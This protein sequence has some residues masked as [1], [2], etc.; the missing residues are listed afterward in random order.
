MEADARAIM[1]WRYPPPYAV[2]NTE[3]DGDADE[4]V[5][6]AEYLD[7]RSPYFA[8]RNEALDPSGAVVG[9]F[10]YGSS[11][12]VSLEA[13]APHLLEADGSLNVGLG[14]RPDLT[15]RGLGLDFVL[16]GLAFGAEQYH[17]TLFRFYALAFNH[18]ALKVYE[19]AGFR[20]VGVVTQ[21]GLWGE[22]DFI[23]LVKENTAR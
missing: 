3:A 7:T 21:R 19:R 4:A 10:C 12:G 5:L 13:G 11:A 20:R 14:M 1:A 8:V 15:G 6:F 9:L 18:R 23:E 17:P 16:A 22:R 2:Y